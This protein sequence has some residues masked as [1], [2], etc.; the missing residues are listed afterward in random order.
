M[1]HVN[2]TFQ[3]KNRQ[4]DDLRMLVNKFLIP[5]VFRSE[6]VKTTTTNFICW[7]VGVSEPTTYNHE[8]FPEKLVL[9][10]S[11]HHAN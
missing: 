3:E 4:C 8:F 6:I 9:F 1:E 11:F 7:Q 2:L 10:F 5:P